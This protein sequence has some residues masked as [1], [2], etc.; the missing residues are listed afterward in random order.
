MVEESVTMV[1]KKRQNQGKPVRTGFPHLPK[2]NRLEF[3]EIRI[4]GI[5]KE[6]TAGLPLFIHQILVFEF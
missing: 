5:S 1:Y 3:K 6:K 4:W 2:T